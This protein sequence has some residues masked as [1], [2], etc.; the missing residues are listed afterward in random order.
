MWSFFIF[1]RISIFKLFVTQ[2][3]STL[4]MKRGQMIYFLYC[5]RLLHYVVK[6][7]ILTRMIIKNT[8]ISKAPHCITTDKKSHCFQYFMYLSSKADLMSLIS[9]S[10]DLS[11][12]HGKIKE[13]T[14]ISQWIAKPLKSWNIWTTNDGRV[15]SVLDPQIGHRVKNYPIKECLENLS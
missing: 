3:F 10:I 6:D 1:L 7:K 11:S 4:F 2:N 12:I 9:K 14:T 15:V 13:R 8:R 5:K